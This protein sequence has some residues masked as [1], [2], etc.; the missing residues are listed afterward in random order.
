MSVGLEQAPGGCTVR[1]STGHPR[2][3]RT[4]APTG[5]RGG[6]VNISGTTYELVKDVV[7]DDVASTHRVD[8]RS[9]VAHRPAFTF[10]PPRGKIHANGKGELE[11]NVVRGL[12]A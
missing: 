11:K 12:E 10:T 4:V 7:E 2:Q 9:G 1:A 6:Q 5:L 3:P 8:P